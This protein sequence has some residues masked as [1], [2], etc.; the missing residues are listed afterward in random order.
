MKIKKG[1]M[2]CPV[3]G[4]TMVIATGELEKEFRGMIKL[5]ESS[6]DIWKWLEEGKEPEEIYPLYAATYGIGLELAKSDVDGLVEQMKEAGIF[7]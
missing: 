7:E 2:L 4:K 1:F 3:M 6:T 5:N